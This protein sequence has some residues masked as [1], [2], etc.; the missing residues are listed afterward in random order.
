MNFTFLNRE[1]NG[2]VLVTLFV[3]SL[4]LLLFATI[5]FDFDRQRI[6]VD[7]D[8]LLLLFGECLLDCSQCHFRKRSDYF[9]TQITERKT[10]YN[11]KWLDN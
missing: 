4:R 6:F 1:S 7:D 3:G 2:L 5:F 10:Q 11:E 9:Q 8:F